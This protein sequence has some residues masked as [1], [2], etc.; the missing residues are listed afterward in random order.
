MSAIFQ[1]QRQAHVVFECPP[2]TNRK[3]KRGK[4]NFFFFFP[5]FSFVRERLRWI[6][7]DDQYA[8]CRLPATESIFGNHPGKGKREKEC[9]QCRR[10]MAQC[11]R[12]ITYVLGC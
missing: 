2:A 10:T 5:P 7:L 1:P 6:T 4:K 9:R 11:F 12:N 8:G 3:T